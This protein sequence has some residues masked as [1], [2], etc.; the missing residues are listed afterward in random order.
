MQAHAVKH[1][2]VLGMHAVLCLL[3]YEGVGGLHN[4]VGALHPTLCRETVQE[5]G[6]LSSM[7]HQIT[8]HLR[9]RS[10]H[11]VSPPVAEDNSSGL[12][13]AQCQGPQAERN[14]R[15]T[16]EVTMVVGS[17]LVYEGSLE[18]SLTSD[19]RIRQNCL[20]RDFSTHQFSSECLGCSTS[21]SINYCSQRQGWSGTL[22]AFYT[23]VPGRNPS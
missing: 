16:N 12:S 17:G 21:I 13:M 19:R 3:E 5:L 2:G 4:L 11:S 7:P 6:L 18:R 14:V 23:Y 22:A 10:I 9:A 20:L 8:S 1:D 15:L